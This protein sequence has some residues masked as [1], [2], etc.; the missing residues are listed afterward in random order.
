MDMYY[1]KKNVIFQENEK[2][3]WRIAYFKS[4]FMVTKQ[5]F[6]NMISSFNLKFH[7]NLKKNLNFAKN[8]SQSFVWTFQK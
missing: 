1:E 5:K 8:N 7:F 3:L 6:K 2:H 4:V